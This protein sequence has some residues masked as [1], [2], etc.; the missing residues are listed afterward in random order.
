MARWLRSVSRVRTLQRR[1]LNRARLQALF[2]FKIDQESRDIIRHIIVVNR[3]M[4]NLIWDGCT[5]LMD[6]KNKY[7]LLSATFVKHEHKSLLHWVWDHD[8]DDKTYK[9]LVKNSVT[10]YLN[11]S[12]N[13]DEFFTLS[14]SSQ[15]DARVPKEL[16]HSI[17]RQVRVYNGRFN[18]Y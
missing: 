10:R 11:F 15:V 4:Q 3:A 14:S 9:T 2:N 13:V 12:R 1:L 7:E 17:P 6:E 18:V 5:Y 16:L 8:C